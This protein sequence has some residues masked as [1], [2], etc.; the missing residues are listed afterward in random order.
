MFYWKSANLIG[1]PTVFYSLI[2]IIVRLAIRSENYSRLKV[3]GCDAQEFLLQQLDL[4]S[5][6]AA[7]SD[8][9]C[10]PPRR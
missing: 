5:I 3:L 10:V 7:L 6:S 4:G 8:P 9:V 1:S 2:N